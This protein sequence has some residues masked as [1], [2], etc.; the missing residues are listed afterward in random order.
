[1]C[2]RQGGRLFSTLVTLAQDNHGHL[3]LP[4]PNY[5]ERKSADST[6]DVGAVS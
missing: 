3:N 2:E 6:S 5:V 1:M 4:I